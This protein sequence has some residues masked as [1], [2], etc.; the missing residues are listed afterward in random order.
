[1]LARWLGPPLLPDVFSPR[2]RKR[3]EKS[4]TYSGYWIV[5]AAT[6]ET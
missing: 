5:E 3:Q 6:T 1:M 4:S 2:W